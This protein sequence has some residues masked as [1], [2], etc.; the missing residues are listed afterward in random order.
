M[1]L[2][3]VRRFCTR[4]S[5]PSRAA[6]AK[7]LGKGSAADVLRG[8]ERSTGVLGAPALT[9]EWLAADPQVHSAL[10]ASP[11]RSNA[12]LGRR[13]SPPRRMTTP[14]RTWGRAAAP[15]RT[16]GWLHQGASKAGAAGRQRNEREIVLSIGGNAPEHPGQQYMLHLFM[17]KLLFP[18]NPPPTQSCAS[19]G[20]NSGKRGLLAQTSR[21]CA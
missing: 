15:H 5:A 20:G 9:P 13:E 8:K 4:L 7:I 12:R 17:A 21:G 16:R 2:R 14:K 1:A 3:H 10:T 6:L 19:R 11:R 18:C